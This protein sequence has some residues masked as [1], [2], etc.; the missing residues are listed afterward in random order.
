MNVDFLGIGVQKGG[1]TW[2]YHQMGRHPQV[3][4]PAGKEVHFWNR[5]APAVAD[6]W[7]AALQPPSR[8]TADGRPIRCGEITPAYAM[9]DPGAIRAL[10]RTCPAIRLFISL[11]NPLTRAWSA[12]M[13]AL[14][15]AQMLEHEASDQWFIDHFRSQA[16]RRRAAYADTLTRWWD[17]FP[18]DQLFVTLLDDIAARPAEVLAGL[19]AHLRI[20]AA[21]FGMLTM[22]DTAA[23]IVPRVGPP[24]TAE[25]P[26]Y[27]TI[28]PTLVPV[29]QALYATEIERLGHLLGRDLGG[30]LHDHGS[31]AVLSGAEAGG[32]LAV[33]CRGQGAEMADSLATAHPRACGS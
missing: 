16:S 11:R 8:L 29:L 1:T 17:A 20:D 2:L 23:V 32:R 7:I 15:R 18:K 19:A 14:T 26:P 5:C 9:L 10:Q 21:D 4:F 24:T 12:A 3:A 22:S 28:R 6:R 13:M 33:G 31:F 27:P 30:W 25:P